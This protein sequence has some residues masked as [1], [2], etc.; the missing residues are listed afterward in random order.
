MTRSHRYGAAYSSTV[1]A[2][3]PLAQIVANRRWQ[4]RLTPFPHVI[5]RDVFVPAV[6]AEIQEAVGRVLADDGMG[7]ITRYDASGWSFP[8][9]IDW[10]LR[11]FTTRAWHDLISTAVDATTI[12]YVSGAIHHHEVGGESGRP[13]NDL[14]PVYF[15]EAEPR[16]GMVLLDGD[17]VDLKTGATRDEGVAVRRTTRAVSILYY[18]A[19]PPWHP[20][21]GGETGLYE[22]RTDPVARPAVRVPPINNS[23]VAFACTPNSFHS[24]ISNRVSPRTS[25]T[26]WLHAADRDPMARWG[27]P[28]LELWRESP[29]I[30]G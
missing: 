10:P 20:G 17:Q 13:H 24:F 11:L 29:R 19:N 23:L 26:M 15:A 28:S 25:I 12:A 6:A 3:R 27:E 30:E 9:D 16:D 4:K 22:R 5:A 8:P 1:E 14:N 18:A 21:D 7:P 2:R